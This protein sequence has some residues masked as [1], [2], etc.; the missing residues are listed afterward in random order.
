MRDSSLSHARAKGKTGPAGN[1]K[2][3]SPRSGPMEEQALKQG[4][5]IRLLG[6]LLV[7]MAPFRWRILAAV[8]LILAATAIDLAVPYITKFAIDQYIVPPG[9]S[10]EVRYVSV[11]GSDE[12]AL[13]VARANPGLFESTDGT[14]RIRLSNLSKLA[15]QD[16]T[17][18]RKKD[19]TGV[20]RAAAILMACV[21]C[22]FFFS[23]WQVWIIE[24]AGQRIMGALRVH[25]FSHILSLD[26]AFFNRQPVGR[27]TTRVTNDVQNM[28]EFFTSVVAMVFKDFFLLAGIA[29]MLVWL[30]WDLA[31]VVF[32]VLPFGGFYLHP[33][34][35]PGPE[36]F[37][38]L[39][40]LAAKIN[41]HVSETIG[42]IRVI[43]LFLMEK[44]IL[45][46]F[47]R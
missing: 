29:A 20:F 31:L 12:N 39:R 27:L 38:D 22:G 36:A 23:F 13:A 17:A 16:L 44:T 18:V 30:S 43:Q 6:R 15:P 28:N 7:F 24:G 47:Q 5:D 40:V 2:A 10:G 34:F 1:E 37:R 26:L 19:L 25:L 4:G 14:F 33:V 9:E 41:T 42:G 11:D 35:P 8:A 3:E 21:V 45:P 32:S 46:G